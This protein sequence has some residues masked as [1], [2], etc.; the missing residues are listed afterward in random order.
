MSAD[1]LIIIVS[2]NG[3]E[4]IGQTLGSLIKAG[5]R[6]L[7]KSIVIDNA[8]QDKTVDMASRHPIKPKVVSLKK[9][10][11][12]AAAYN[13]G[14]EIALEQKVKWMLLLDQDSLLT[15]KSL[16]I[17]LGAAHN[18]QAAGSNACT[19]FPTPKCAR[20]PWVVHHPYIWTDNQLIE[21]KCD[22]KDK[23]IIPVNSSITSGALYKPDALYSVQ[24]FREN[25]F[26]DFVDH[27]CHLRLMRHGYDMWWVC[28]AEI[29]HNLGA[30]Q[31]FV[32]KSLWIEH[33]PFRYY[34][35]ARNMT[36]G[37]YRLGGARALLGFWNHAWH[38]MLLVRQR[39]S[40]PSKCLKFFI[41]G[42]LHAL[43]GK[44]GPLDPSS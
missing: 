24:G 28:E 27:E 11:G 3:E 41:K 13:L 31:R 29:L 34:Y 15:P 32:K 6:T 30:A 18:Q 44:T 8:S 35:M 9:N 23:R 5:P 1:V 20:Y 16:D 21:A 10:S 33:E 38:H 14:L 12:V 17:L 19:F 7:F 36:E 22:I 39:N 26:I 43:Q 2:F 40:D 25:Y 42:I 37:Y 4:T